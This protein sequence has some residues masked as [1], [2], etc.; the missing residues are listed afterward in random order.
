MSITVTPIPRL[1]SLVAPNFGVGESN[2]AGSATTAVS[3]NS[4][5]GFLPTQAEMEAST[6]NVK[7][8]T[9]GTAKFHPGVAKAWVSFDYSGG[10]PT[11][12]GSY[13]VSSLGDDGTGHVQVNYDDDLSSAH[14][15]TVALPQTNTLGTTTVGT[16][17]AVGSVDLKTSNASQSPTDNDGSCIVFGDM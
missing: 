1:I 14:G 13:N 4:T 2:V 6:S 10:T 7:F 16:S 12:M 8:V 11:N 3:S 17:Q 9:P 5:L 15:A